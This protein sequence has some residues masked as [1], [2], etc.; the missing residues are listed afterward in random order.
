MISNIHN[1]IKRTTEVKELNWDV[2][3]TKS[4]TYKSELIE[5]G[6]TGEWSK[7]ILKDSLPQF[8]W[9]A[10]LYY[11][12]HRLLDII[13]DSAEIDESFFCTHIN[14]HNESFAELLKE[15]LT[16][17]HSEA[18]GTSKADIIDGELDYLKELRLYNRILS[19]LD[20]E[21]I[22]LC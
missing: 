12:K 7:K 22:A 10:E 5:K 20:L 1:W 8:I 13:F 9:V 2:Y 17:S 21:E 3:L 11:S 18:D 15:Y 16:K 6:R 4:N 19:S 14:Y